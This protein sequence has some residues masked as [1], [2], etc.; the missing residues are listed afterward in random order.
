[1]QR[2]LMNDHRGL[3]SGRGDPRKRPARMSLSQYNKE[4]AEA[5]EQA[6]QAEQAYSKDSRTIAGYQDTAAS[7]NAFLQTLPSE[8]GNW[9]AANPY[10]CIFFIQQYWLPAHKG[11]DS[12]RV[13]PKYLRSMVSQLS[14]NFIVRGRTGE[15][16]AGAMSGNPTQSHEVRTFV[17]TY[18]KESHAKGY[19]ERSAVPMPKVCERFQIG[20]PCTDCDSIKPNIPDYLA[21]YRASMR[22][23]RA[24][25]IDSRPNT[26]AYL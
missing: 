9:Q 21:N 15:W 14:Y 22:Y 1:M 2:S 20:L 24:F 10:D 16:Q 6:A 7:F 4:M 19:R 26:R 13:C 23:T 8:C 25:A 5:L 11:R 12:D 17:R 3:A 18:G